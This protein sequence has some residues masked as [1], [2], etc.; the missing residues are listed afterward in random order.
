LKTQLWLSVSEHFS[1]VCLFVFFFFFSFFAPHKQHK[2][3]WGKHSRAAVEW[4]AEEIWSVLSSF[5]ISSQKAAELQPAP[6]S[7]REAEGKLQERERE[8]E[9]EAQPGGPM[10]Q[11]VPGKQTRRGGHAYPPTQKKF[12][13]Q[14]GRF[15]FSFSF[16]GAPNNAFHLSSLMTIFIKN[17]GP[18]RIFYFIFWWRIFTICDFLKRKIISQITFFLVVKKTFFSLKKWPKII[19]ILPTT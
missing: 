5:R 8:R 16:W 6:A 18:L 11:Q 1:F 15:L 7:A 12:G 14:L 10:K 17:G 19:I 13:G 2:I 4:K 9:R 3:I